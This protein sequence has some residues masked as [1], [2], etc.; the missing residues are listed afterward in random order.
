MQVEYT[1]AATTAWYCIDDQDW[2]NMFGTPTS[3]LTISVLALENPSDQLSSSSSSSS[4]DLSWTKWNSKNVM[5]LRKKSTDSWTEPTQG[6]AYSVGNSIGSCT[7]IYN[8][9]ETSFTDTGLEPNT[10]YDY[11]FYSENYSYYSAGITSSAT[12]D[13]TSSTDY[14]RSKQSGNWHVASNWESSPNNSNWVTSTAIPESSANTI[15]IL[16]SHEI[17]LDNDVSVNSIVIDLG[18][19]L[20]ANDGSKS[21]IVLTIL[22]GGT[23]TNNGTFNALEGLVEL[24]GA[25][26]VTGTVLFYDVDISGTINF[27]TDATISNSLEVLAGGHVF[28]GAPIYQE[29]SSL[30]F[31]TG[32]DFLIFNLTTVWVNGDIVG[33]GVP[34]N[35]QVVSGCT[36]LVN[37]SRKVVGDLNINDGATV[38]QGPHSF[39]IYGD[40]NNYGYYKFYNSGSVSLVV[41]G[42]VI[43]GET[44]NIELS[45]TSGGDIKIAGNFTDN[46]TFIHNDR[47]V[48]FNG[49]SQ[50]LS[51]TSETSLGYVYIENDAHVTLAYD[52]DLNIDHDFSI[53]DGSKAAGS[54][55][56]ESTSS[57]TGSLITGG[58]V[59]ANIEVE[60]Y[61]EGWTT[62]D[63]G[64]HLLSIPFESVIVAPSDFAPGATDDLYYYDEPSDMWINWKTGGSP[65]ADPNFDFYA[66]KGYLCSYED[67]EIKSFSGTLNSVD[68]F[69]DDLTVEGN[70]TRTEAGWNMIG[71][72]Y[73]SSVLWSN[74]WGTNINAVAKIYPGTGNYIDVDP[75]NG[76]PSAQAFFVQVT[77]ETDLTIPISARLH[78][79]EAWRKSAYAE[80]ETLSFEIS[81][82]TN[83]LS[84]KTRIR[85]AEEATNEFDTQF[86]AF[87]LF[88]MAT[89]PQLYTV[90]SEEPYS[91]NTYAE[92]KLERVIDLEFIPGTSGEH[93][94]ELIENTCNEDCLVL[95]DDKFNNITVDMTTNKTYQFDANTADDPSRFQ[96]RFSAVGIDEEV[97]KESL[98]AYISGDHLYIL[99]EEG[100]AE[101]GVFNIQGQQLLQEK[102]A[103]N[104]QYN[105]SLNLKSGFYL[106]SLQ[107]SEQ[108]KTAKI[109]IK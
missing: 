5:I 16:N 83:T 25:I 33:P 4:I 29:G 48:F 104:S 26:T 86:D 106:V 67:D 93:Q 56:I 31:N 43:N 2:E 109:I 24:A 17:T 41:K 18:G 99:G 66:G 87:K 8:S 105:R 92:I 39:E 55:K 60:R 101:L 52:K 77:A 49:S 22:D 64:W 28:G 13:N 21:D 98:Q 53:G 90:V 38:K 82:G 78:S 23:F 91:T 36:L 73:A 6:V 19:T 47:A 84:D 69:V 40:L 74:A 63:D 88:G 46:G 94:I 68:V 37:D 65:N 54:F 96:I 81:G 100:I 12:T 79:D 32:G 107:T 1:D 76:I 15:T 42:D 71:N 20:N 58:T 57:G 51:G 61:I 11:K 75:V 59:P 34:D 103:L 35:V 7:V 3:D 108:T 14:F 27:G 80:L 30:I 62:A 72:P 45:T 44:G 102:V 95:L 9:N 50:R 97:Q 89:A 70:G 10:S 85:F